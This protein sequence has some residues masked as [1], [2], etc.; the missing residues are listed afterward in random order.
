[1]IELKTYTLVNADAVA[2]YT[3]DFWPRHIRSL[4]EYGITIHGLWT[5]A[6]TDSNRVIALIEHPQDENSSQAANR[7][8]A[9]QDFVDDHADFDVRLIT[10]EQTVRLQA[11]EA[12]PPLITN[13]D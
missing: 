4:H 6:S 5:E 11:V 10:D 2:K 8:R 1:M 3:T 9:S 7:Y 12:S 13:F